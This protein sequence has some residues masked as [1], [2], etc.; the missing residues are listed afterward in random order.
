M[1]GRLFKTE[2]LK[3]KRKWVWFLIFLGPFG[4]IAMETLNFVLRYDYLT[5]QYAGHLWG[6]LFQAI[7]FLVPPV[8]ILGMAI[9]ISILANIEH[10]NASWKQ[11]LAA[12]VRKRQVFL[13]KF[14]LGW[15]LLLVSCVLLMIGALILGLALGFGTDIAWKPLL[16]TS[17]YPYLAAMPILAFQIWL[18]IVYKNQGVALTTGILASVFSM[19]GVVMPDWVPLAWP[20]LQTHWSNPVMNVWLGIGL[21][22]CILMIGTVDFVRR[23]VHSG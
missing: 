8:I 20:S 19:Y 13:V 2:L 7:G 14:A 21:A 9:I 6:G 17:F 16:V 3:I 18:A 12:P 23:D 22:F 11:L 15:L 5:K 4:V 10:A 1:Y